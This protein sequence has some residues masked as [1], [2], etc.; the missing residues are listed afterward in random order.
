VARR[1]HQG[2]GRYA[3]SSVRHRG[4]PGNYHRRRLRGGSPGSPHLRGT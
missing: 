2:G 4:S 3:A 1:G